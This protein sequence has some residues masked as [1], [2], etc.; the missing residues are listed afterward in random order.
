MLVCVHNDYAQTYLC[1]EQLGAFLQSF[2]WCFGHMLHTRLHVLG[3]YLRARLAVLVC[4]KRRARF[5][6][7]GFSF[8]YIIFCLDL[9]MF[10]LD[11]RIFDH[12]LHP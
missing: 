4:L 2:C 8:V 1:F 9:N 11:S 10:A 6:R 3:I 5:A 12:V 7:F